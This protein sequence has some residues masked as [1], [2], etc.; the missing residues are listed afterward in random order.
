MFRGKNGI[1]LHIVDCVLGET[2]H[3]YYRGK[4]IEGRF[5]KVT[6]CGY[7]FLHEPSNQCIMKD[8]WYV[9]TKYKNYS[10]G[11]LKKFIVPIS[12][13]ARPVRIG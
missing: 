2:Y 1:D 5:I 11:P 10:M 13:D 4:V 9:P 7:N 12:R 3:V 8:H 6:N